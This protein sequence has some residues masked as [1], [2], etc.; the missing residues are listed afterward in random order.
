MNQTE[1]KIDDK[2]K[3]SDSISNQLIE[4]FSIR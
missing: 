2:R 4:D 3:V 1:E